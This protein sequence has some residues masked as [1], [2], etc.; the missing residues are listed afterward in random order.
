[1]LTNIV[2]SKPEDVKIGMSVEVTFTD[3]TCELKFVIDNPEPKASSIT[4]CP[5]CS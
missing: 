3:P 5:G 1:M 4:A 2:E